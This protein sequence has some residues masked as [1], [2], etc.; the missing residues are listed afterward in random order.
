MPL[1]ISGQCCGP[2]PQVHKTRLKIQKV[3]STR[4]GCPTLSVSN[5]VILD[6]N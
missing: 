3:F 6:A 1:R 5:V 2:A 4:E